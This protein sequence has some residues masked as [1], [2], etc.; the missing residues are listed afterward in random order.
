MAQKKQKDLLEDL[1]F[2]AFFDAVNEL[3]E[4]ISHLPL[5]QQRAIS[6]QFFIEQNKYYEPVLRI[7]DMAVPGTQG[8]MVPMRLYI[9]NDSKTLPVLLYFHGGGWVYGG[10]AESD[11]VCRRLANHLGCM[12]A[13]VG[14]RLAPEFPFPKA[15]EDCYA[16]TVWM[17]MNRHL[18]GSSN[19]PCMVCGESSGGNLAAAVALLAR[20]NKGPKIAAQLLIY[21]V[22]TSIIQDAI[23]DQCPDH[24]FLTKD[25]MRSFWEMYA[26]S[27]GDAKDAHASLDCGTDFTDLPPA[28]IIA[29]EYDPLTHDIESYALKLEKAGIRVI[30]KIYPGLVHGFLYIPLY[31]DV[32]KVAWT[33]EIG[34]LLHEVVSASEL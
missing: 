7:E 2:K 14:Y 6:G 13:S 10:I 1:Q 34:A 21:P 12:V 29:A 25:A 16:A 9:P 28:V 15:L 23:Y 17:A 33:K 19:T 22:I 31:E 4:S 26:Q 3:E 32:K 24:Y 5:S 11:A 20:D 27:P 30:K 8:H 18:Y